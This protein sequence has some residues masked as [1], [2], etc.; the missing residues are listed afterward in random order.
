MFQPTDELADF[1][2]N[3]DTSEAADAD[4]ELALAQF[5][6]TPEQLRAEIEFRQR[7]KEEAMLL[8][9][10]AVQRVAGERRVLKGADGEEGVVDM[11]WDP[12]SYH[13]W[14]RRL[15]YECWDDPQFL[16]EYKRDN[17]AVRIKTIGTPGAETV[18]MAKNKAPAQR[19]GPKGR[20][21]RWAL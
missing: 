15:G 11:V 17:E 18:A 9:L 20:R 6:V 19:S 4:T 1:S 7:K 12:T 14:G 10:A 3:F 13:Y 21:G 8:R 2:A 5:G 16:R